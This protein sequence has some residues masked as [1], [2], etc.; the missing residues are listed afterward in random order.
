MKTEGATDPLRPLG[1]PNRSK[2][3]QCKAWGC[4]RNIGKKMLTMNFLKKPRVSLF[5][6]T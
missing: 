6:A 4:L 2:V 5:A 3:S 1:A